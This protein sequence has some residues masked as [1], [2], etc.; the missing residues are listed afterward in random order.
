MRGDVGDP[1][2][3]ELDHEALDGA[4]GLIARQSDGTRVP[5]LTGLLLLA[6]STRRAN[7]LARMA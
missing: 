2:L 6:K 1:I 5:T 7:W 4:L 3:L